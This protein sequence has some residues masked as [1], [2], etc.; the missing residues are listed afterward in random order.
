MRGAVAAVPVALGVLGGTLTSDAPPNAASFGLTAD[1][2]L[3]L[4]ATPVTWP[5]RN[6]L[7][8]EPR[9]VFGVPEYEDHDDDHNI[10]REYSGFTVYYDDEILGPRWTAIKLTAE[11]ADLHNEVKRERNFTKDT[12]IE[13]AGYEVTV[14]KD[15]NNPPGSRKWARGHIVQFDDARGWGAQSGKDSFF[16]SN[17]APQL[18]SHN[19]KGW[20]TLEKTCTEFA[21]DYERVWIYCGP[22]YEDNPKPFAANRKVPKPVAFYKIVVSPGDNDA[23]DVLAFRMPQEHP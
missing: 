20:L 7:S 15:Y 14:H 21:R 8:P 18:Q 1:E 11:M 13:D 4:E 10:L 16:T 6:A 17:I 12:Q 23:V 2:A 9:T 22:I 3:A 5:P 19:S